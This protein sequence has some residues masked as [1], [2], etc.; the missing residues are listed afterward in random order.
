MD[1]TEFLKYI[2]VPSITKAGLYSE[3]AA[4]LML[5]TALAESNLDLLVQR[6]NGGAKSFFQIEDETYHDILRYL[7]R[8]DK[9]ALRHQIIKACQ[10]VSF[11]N[12]DALIYNMRLATI[13]ARVKYLMSPDPLPKPGA[14]H[15]QG[16]YW[17]K[18]YNCGGKATVNKYIDGWRFQ[19]R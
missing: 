12:P 11:P 15:A 17:V 8:S 14:V 10:I 13:I 2:I 18:N 7:N 9:S 16:E 1:S 5:G 3:S 19:H 6:Y 4:N